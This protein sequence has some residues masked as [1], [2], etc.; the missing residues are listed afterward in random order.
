MIVDRIKGTIGIALGACFLALNCYILR[1][2]ALRVVDD[3][4]IAQALGI[5]AA[6]I[7][8]AVAI[9]PEMIPDTWRMVDIY[10]ARIPRPTIWTAVVAALWGLLI[11]VNLSTGAGAI[12]MSRTHKVDETVK[13][14]DD[15]ADA[16]AARERL[17]KEQGWIPA[18]RPAEMVEGLIEK[19]KVSKAYTNSNA[20]AEPKTKDQR[21]T[22]KT[23]ADLT[24]ELGA[25]NKAADL[26]AKITKLDETIRSSGPAMSAA[27]AD[28]FSS[29]VA[30]W[31]GVS[32]GNVRFWIS[33][34]IPLAIEGCAAF[35]IH[36]SL[37]AFMR[38]VPAAAAATPAQSVET[39]PEA[40]S[41]PPKAIV[42]PVAHQTVT[43]AD[44][45]RASDLARMFLGQC[46]RP[47]PAGAM[48]ERDW[49]ARYEGLCERQRAR[50]IIVEQFRRLAVNHGI[51]V[52]EINGEPVYRGFL[53]VGDA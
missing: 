22:C 13:A 50:P 43:T 26:S 49:Y 30:A 24:A 29:Q 38:G 31:T 25:G 16:K 8:I 3:P 6:L 32:T 11:A 18:H 37:S 17:L 51:R 2:G 52:D 33:A 42:A 47:S 45:K 23:I 4:E 39:A 5:G 15:L 46:T 35:L 21:D 10:I 27:S 7:P 40:N 14:S 48:P 1:L 19:A 41:G 34:M 44:L 9:I 28:P 12:L 53:P 36:L 20:C